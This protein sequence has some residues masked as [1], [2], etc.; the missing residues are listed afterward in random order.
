MF[1]EHRNKD[2]DADKNIIPGDGV[3][4]GLGQR[5]DRTGCMVYVYA[6]GLHGLRRIAVRNRMRRR[7]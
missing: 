5:S 2:F 4:T 7:S 3:V 6:E 1:I